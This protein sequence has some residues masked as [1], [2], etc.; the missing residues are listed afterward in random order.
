MQELDHNIVR[1]ER[2]LTILLNRYYIITTTVNL[3]LI[4]FISKELNIL[5]RPSQED[6][7]RRKMGPGRGRRRTT[8]E[9]VFNK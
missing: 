3:Q 1:V 6:R 7:R 2:P 4:V 9:K 8:S 5:G